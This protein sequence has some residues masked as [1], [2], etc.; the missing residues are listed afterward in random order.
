MK[1]KLKSVTRP[2]GSLSGTVN[3]P[4]SKSISNRM[5]MM[6][7]LAGENFTIRNLSGADDTLLLEQLLKAVRFREGEKN[8][9]VLDTQNAGTVMRFL[10][11]YLA[12]VPGKWILDG[13]DRMK[14]R[15][16]GEL[17]EALRCLGADIEYVS[18]L[19]YPPLII[20]GK[21][22]R[23]ETVVVNPGISSQF[24]SALLMIGPALPDGLRI[25]MKGEAVSFPYVEMTIRLM[26]QTGILVK[27]KGN[28]L[29]VPAGSP[30]PGEYIVEPD[31]SSAS[32]W[33]EAAA[34]ADEAEIV[35]AGLMQD[36]IQGD[37]ALP[38]IFQNF[39]VMTE[40]S[41]AG[42]TLTRVRKKSDG[43]Y[44]DFSGH[45]DIALP[46]ITTCALQG[47]RGRFEGLKS[48]RVKETDRIAS[49]KNELKKVGI[50]LD[51]DYFD[52]PRPVID[53]PAANLKIV[54]GLHFFS[55]DDHRMAMTFAMAAMK[56]GSVVIENPDVVSKSY[57]GFWGDLESM[58]FRVE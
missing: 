7:V 23:S 36:S 54:P 26:K 55:Y 44:F 42:A 6:Q 21:K 57:P 18:K 29:F 33:Y 4:F 15:P 22:L 9:T 41:E 30:A 27:K 34:L 32:F 2:E 52:D 46:V 50:A 53:F 49:L 31:W 40:F 43:F 14:N 37:A 39:G 5:L 51:P 28:D 20:K 25:R 47:L 13:S 48:L 56:T 8:M 10:T 45:P 17:V 58:G 19:G 35:L 12:M 38:G 11:A 3:L 24:L 16:V 1:P